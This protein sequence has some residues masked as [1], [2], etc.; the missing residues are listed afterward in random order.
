MRSVLKSTGGR[1]RRPFSRARSSLLAATVVGALVALTACSA[2]SADSSSSNASTIVVVIPDQATQLSYDVGWTA[3]TDF[4]EM[5]GL[6]NANLIRKPYA[7]TDDPAIVKQDLYNF[8]GVLA[9]SYDLSADNTTVTFH[10]RQGVMSEHG[11]EFT[12]NDVLWSYERKFGS[13]TSIVKYVTAPALTDPD[14]QF[15]VIDKY[16]ISLTVPSSG[17]MFTM[18]SVLADVTGQ[19]YDSTYL[20]ENATPD[21]PWATKWSTGR[22]DFMMGAYRVESMVE[23]SE[24]VL[25][26]NPGYALG[27][28][29]ITKIIRRVVADAG[30]RV[31]ALQSGDADVALGLRSSDMATL[32]SNTKFIVPDLAANN[33]YFLSLTTTVAPFDN[34]AVRQAMAYAIDYDQIISQVF[35]GRATNDSTFLWSDAPGYDGTDLPR[36]S[37]D[38]AKAESMLAAAGI[39]TPVSFTLTVPTSESTLQD[40]AVSIQSSAAAAGFSVDIESIPYAQFAEKTQK[41]EAQANLSPGSAFSLSPSY[42]LSLFTTPGASTNTSQ[43]SNQEFQD[44]VQAGIDSGD[45]L[46][47]TAGAFW[48]KAEQIWLGQDVPMIVVAKSKAVSAVNGEKLTGWTWRTDNSIYYSVM[49]FK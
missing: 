33:F 21:D 29:K 22:T 47:P 32:A 2:G 28:P 27:T 26:A 12:A 24:T 10:L 18:L 5:Q 23:G 49:T 8:E 15:T 3:S 31:N 48:N 45:A 44:T 6:I 37:Y 4:A 40:A 39:T 9:E 42:E 35:A 14:K 19:L 20:K 17:S 25:V 13:D 30:S 41:G 16:T 7:A 46:T 43:W 34:V 38:P 1:G 36:Y 11:N